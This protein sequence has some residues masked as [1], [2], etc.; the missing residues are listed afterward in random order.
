MCILVFLFLFFQEKA[1]KSWFEKNAEAVE[2]IVENNDSEDERVQNHKQK[3]ASSAQ[4]KKL[5]QVS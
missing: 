1:N 2:L 5:Q 4:L 3:K